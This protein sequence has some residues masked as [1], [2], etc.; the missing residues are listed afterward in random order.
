MQL[1]VDRQ[2]HVRDRAVLS[3]DVEPGFRHRELA[4]LALRQGVGASTSRGDRN[5]R[6]LER[7]Y[8]RTLWLISL[9][10]ILYLVVVH[11]LS[12]FRG[13]PRVADIHMDEPAR[14]TEGMR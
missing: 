5:M 2:E 10:L 13:R 8:V 3:V 9:A 12:A 14:R 7:L 4:A 1:E 6:Q 11:E